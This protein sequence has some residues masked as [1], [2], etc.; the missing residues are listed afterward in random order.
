MSPLIILHCSL[1][2]V[3]IAGLWMSSG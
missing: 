2:P 3:M 1:K